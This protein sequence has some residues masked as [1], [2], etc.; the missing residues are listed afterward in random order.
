M[1]KG[2]RKNKKPKVSLAE[3]KLERKNKR[4]THV[5]ELYILPFRYLHSKYLQDTGKLVREARDDVVNS[6]ADKVKDGKTRVLMG[7]EAHSFLSEFL[8]LIE[9]KMKTILCRKSP[10]FW[11]YLYRRIGLG[12]ISEEG[13]KADP[14]TLANVRLTV[15][16]AML[17]FGSLVIQDDMMLS[18]NMKAK[19]VLDGLFFEAFSEGGM[20]PE[21]IDNVWSIYKN[22]W[23]PSNYK[24]SDHSDI[25]I[26]EGYAYEYWRTTAKMRAIGKGSQLIVEPDGTWYEKRSAELDELIL[27]YDRRLMAG[28]GYLSTAKGLPSFN[29]IDLGKRSSMLSTLIV[30]RYNFDR[31]PLNKWLDGFDEE[32]VTNFVP[33]HISVEKYIGAHKMMLELYER[34][35]N[36]SLSSVLAFFSA[37]SIL[38][39]FSRMVGKDQD[40]ENMSFVVFHVLQRAYAIQNMT[41]E[42]LPSALITVLEQSDVSG[43]FVTP[44]MRDEMPRVCRHFFLEP[45][46]REE[47]SLWSHGPRPVIFP[48][49]NHLVLDIGGAQ[50][51]FENL[52]FGIREGAT[53]Q[54]KRGAE[55]EKIVRDEAGAKGYDLLKDRILRYSD[56]E[57][58]EVDLAIRVGD[59]LLLCDCHSSERP[60][61]FVLGKPSTIKRRN[62]LLEKKAEQVISLGAFVDEKRKGLNYDYSWAKKIFSIGILPSVEWIWT[63]HDSFWIDKKQD[64]PVLMSIQELFDFVG[65]LEGEAS[66][67][68]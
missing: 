26:L 56:K 57:Y 38:V 64:L 4:F 42:M 6:Y 47:I 22:N 68:Q 53:I 33:L 67:R 54:G 8:A 21:R 13:E 49:G 40:S 52:F 19:D 63:D 25:Y 9:S 14:S 31:I 50:G 23:V 28:Q 1:S 10:Y 48:Y 61:D 18:D 27:S 20:T 35:W 37:V 65:R 46:K 17:K 12:H 51:I 29:G 15:E 32:T 39:L 66:Q 16:T 7:D 45:T 43:N 5:P 55:L 58:R 59:V 24:R 41:F 2:N 11:F 34:K 60:L 3:K 62:E 30:A 36:F 44:E